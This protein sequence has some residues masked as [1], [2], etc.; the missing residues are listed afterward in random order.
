M[1]VLL[2]ILV[3]GCGSSSAWYGNLPLG[4][5]GTVPSCQGATVTGGGAIAKESS[6]FLEAVA[7]GDATLRCADGSTTRVTVKPIARLAI[8]G[9]APLV[10]DEAGYWLRAYAGNGDE[11]R[12][13]DPDGVV[14]WS[15]EGNA[16]VDGG[17]CNHP[18][19][20]CPDED[21]AK[22]WIRGAGP[23]VLVAQFAG[24]QARLPLRQ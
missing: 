21:Y 4:W 9:P 11:L 20:R 18:L 8:H 24:R 2:V 13:G 14:E 12:L 5:R 1:R 16:E 3:A 23:V 22:V 19:I 15:I 17:Y 6:G 10:D 7:A